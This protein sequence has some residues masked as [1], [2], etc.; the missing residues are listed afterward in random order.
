M[1][2]VEAR[3]ATKAG[4]K[5]QI[6]EAFKYIATAASAGQCSVT[7]PD[8]LAVGHVREALRAKGYKIGSDYVSWT[9]EK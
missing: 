3:E 5:N 1:T 7:L 4:M 6:D 8:R 2:A 9:G